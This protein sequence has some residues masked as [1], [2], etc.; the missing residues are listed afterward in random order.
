M[1]NKII[2]TDL[3]DGITNAY[4]YQ[5]EKGMWIGQK[6]VSKL[7]TKKTLS[8]SILIN[9]SLENIEIDLKK[10]KYIL[11]DKCNNKSNISKH[12]IR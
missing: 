7:K 6:K 4:L 9:G 1:K 3:S 8:F 2:T 10:G 11:F 5:T 12:K